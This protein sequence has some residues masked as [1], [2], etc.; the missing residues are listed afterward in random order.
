MATLNGDDAMAGSPPTTARVHNQQVQES[1]P[2][3]PQIN[4]SFTFISLNFVYY[5]SI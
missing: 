3:L 4:A 2:T 1:D 5:G